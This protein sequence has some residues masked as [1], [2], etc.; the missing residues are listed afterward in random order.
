MVKVS[1]TTSVP[2]SATPTANL[3]SSIEA[4]VCTARLYLHFLRSAFLNMFYNQ[5]AMASHLIA[6]APHLIAMA[7]NLIAIAS[8]LEAMASNLLAMASNLK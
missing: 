4:K 1:L 8:N 6:M 5:I 7:S 2:F 3:A